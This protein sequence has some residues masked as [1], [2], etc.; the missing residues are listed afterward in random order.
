MLDALKKALGAKDEATI[1]LE[2]LVEQV[3]KLQEDLGLANETIA[4]LNESLEG[5]DA[6]LQE[7]TG[8]LS[9]F[10][11]I[12]AEAEAKAEAERLAA[13]E[14]V[15]AIKKEKLAAILGADNP[16]LEAT[17]DAIK[18]LEGDQLTAV[19]NGFAAAFVKEAELPEFKE[20]G[21]TV[22]GKISEEAS[23]DNATARI[24][25]QK[26]QNQ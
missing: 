16:N 1:S 25:K 8:K 22:E 24:L 21:L 2:Q 12:A 18:D 19:F 20:V 26:Y 9:E 15:Q 6:E 17:F 11:D 14:A 13:I 23:T 4:K 5:K 10:A 3:N 7:L